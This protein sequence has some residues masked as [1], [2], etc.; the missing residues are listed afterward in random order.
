M[1]PPRILHAYYHSRFFVQVG[2]ETMYSATG[3]HHFS[4]EMSSSD[5]QRLLWT[6]VKSVHKCY[7]GM[8]IVLALQRSFIILVGLTLTW[9]IEIMMIS[10]SCILTWF[11]A[12]LAQKILNGIYWNTSLMDSNLGLMSSAAHRFGRVEFWIFVLIF[13]HS[14]CLQKTTTNIC[15]SKF[16]TQ[17]SQNV[18]IDELPRT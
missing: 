9:Y 5:L 11:Y 1:R 2:H 13:F 17:L 16:K 7:L 6:S 3:N 14:A 4:L 12:Q 15:Y 10:N 18:Q 8:Y